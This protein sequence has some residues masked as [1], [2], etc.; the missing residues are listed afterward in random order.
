MVWR[1]WMSLAALNMGGG[2]GCFGIVGGNGG[3]RQVPPEGITRG[4]SA[5]RLG[6]RGSLN[7]PIAAFGRG[8]SGGH[9]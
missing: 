3:T 7:R 1:V 5:T 9:R 2:V 8:T 4:K 6:R